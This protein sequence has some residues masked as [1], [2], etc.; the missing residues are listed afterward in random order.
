MPVTHF[1]LTLKRPLADGRGFGDVGPYEELKGRLRFAID[2]TH[3]ANTRITDIER[4]PRS[5]D[6]RVEFAADV[7][8]LLAKCN[9][10]DRV[11]LAAV[12]RAAFE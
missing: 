12:A 1:D 4:A 6:G 2:P 11:Q 9:S 7:S 5:R 10:V 8:I 3:P